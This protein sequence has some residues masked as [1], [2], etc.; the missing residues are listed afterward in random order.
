MSNKKQQSMDPLKKKVK[1][2]GDEFWAGLD[3]IMKSAGDVWGMGPHSTH[4]DIDW[5]TRILKFLVESGYDLRSVEI[6]LLTWTLFHIRTEDAGNIMRSISP[7]IKRDVVA[8]IS[9][10]HRFST[11][12]TLPDFVSSSFLKRVTGREPT[13]IGDSVSVKEEPSIPV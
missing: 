2:F 5:I 11:K 7:E 10:I 6:G 3:A 13:K 4:L 8:I 9:I 12:D 1:E